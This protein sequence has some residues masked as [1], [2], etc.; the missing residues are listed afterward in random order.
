DPTGA[1]QVVTV[2][3]TG[4]TPAIGTQSAQRILYGLLSGATA[5][6]PTT[7]PTGTAAVG[8]VALFAHTRVLSTRTAQAGAN[9]TSSVPATIQLQAGDGAA[10]QIGHIIRILNNTPAGVQNQ[11]RRIIATTGFGT[12]TV[13][14][15]RA[16]GTVPASGTTYEILQGILFD[17]LPNPVT[18]VTR[19]FARSYAAVAGGATTLFYEKIFFVNNNTGI[20]LT[21]AQL[22]VASESPTLPSG[23]LI[24]AALC[25]ALNDGGSVTNRQTAPA[26]GIGPFVTQ[27][28]L[29]NVP[30]PGNLPS[31]AAPNG[32]GAQGMWLRLTLPAGSAAWFGSISL[33]ASGVTT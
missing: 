15:S 21:Q 8:D 30:A 4:T 1:E 16:W 10:V 5:N 18:C 9:P 26:T 19:L 13:A 6:G 22:Q 27:P 31:G 33:A 7:A 3:L 23:D 32:A 20:S 11:L 12:D 29:I 14:V 2:N 24:D 28:A 17:I 25:N